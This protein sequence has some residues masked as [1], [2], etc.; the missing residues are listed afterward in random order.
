MCVS[1]KRGEIV[2]TLHV[3]DYSETKKN[4]NNILMIHDVLL[5]NNNNDSIYLT[6]YPTSLWMAFFFKVLTCFDFFDNNQRG[7]SA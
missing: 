4:Y 2:E 6:G 5:C 1:G 7:W 3:W